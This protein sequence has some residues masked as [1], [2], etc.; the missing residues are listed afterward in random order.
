MWKAVLRRLSNDSRPSFK[1]SSEYIPSSKAQPV[2]RVSSYKERFDEMKEK[3]GSDYET[4]FDKYDLHVPKVEVQED[5]RSSFRRY[6]ER[7]GFA[8]CDL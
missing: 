8:Q 5:N 4:P 7:H 1:L 3:F 2:K 6:H